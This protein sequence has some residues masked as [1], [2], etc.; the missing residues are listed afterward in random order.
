MKMDT[1][2]MYLTYLVLLLIFTLD[3]MK[4]LFVEKLK[5][6]GMA[7]CVHAHFT[8]NDNASSAAATKAVNH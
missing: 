7:A 1:C 5:I 8:L 3:H 2:H 6:N 4:H